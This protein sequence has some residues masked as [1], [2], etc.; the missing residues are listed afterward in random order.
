MKEP[1][2]DV[3]YNIPDSPQHS[4]VHLL[5]LSPLFTALY[6]A[7]KVHVIKLDPQMESNNSPKGTIP[8]FLTSE[9]LLHSIHQRRKRRGLLPVQS[10]RSFCNQ[11]LLQIWMT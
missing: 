7:P 1:S 5:S 2:V 4:V 8:D 9:I 11:F 6:F 10:L 3:G